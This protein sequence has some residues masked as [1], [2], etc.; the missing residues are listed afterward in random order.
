MRTQIFIDH[1]LQGAAEVEAC[2][3]EAEGE[4]PTVA[5]VLVWGLHVREG[6]VG[7]RIHH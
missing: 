6:A 5:V 7:R 1:D 4:G 3:H 2:H